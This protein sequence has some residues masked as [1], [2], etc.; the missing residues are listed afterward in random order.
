MST[1]LWQDPAFPHFYH[2]PAVVKPLEEAFRIEVAALDKRLARL[3]K[4]GPGFEDVLTEEIVA[5]SEIEGVILDRDSVHSS[6]VSNLPPVEEK[7]QGAVAL[8]RMALAHYDEPL[9]HGL[10]H[11]MHREILRGSRFPE[12]SIGSYVGDMKIVSGNRLDQE[13]KV[14]H[15]G[16]SKD[17]VHDKMTEFI[18]WYNQC[19]GD[20]PLVN[21]VQGHVHFET[22]HPFCDGNGR[23]GRNLVLMGLCRDL[24]RNTPLA[25]SRSFNAD[26]KNY[27]RQFEAGLDLTDTIQRVSP[28]FQSAVIETGRI[29]E[30][31]AYRARV[32][33]Q[34][35]DLNERQIKVLNR[36]I[37]Y[38]LR[39]GFKGGLNNAKYQKMTGIGDR[40][41]LRDLGELHARG[42]VVK[43]GQLKGTRYHLNIPHLVKSLQAPS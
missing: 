28:L 10:L 11:T 35:E 18:E 14:I 36:L 30:L 40:T 37:D 24:G 12:E 23:I 39:G 13:P 25:L 19:P 33:D 31:T 4:G 32:S 26:L 9:N 5:N 41:A 3:G 29:L 17:L 6:F 38:E 21:A 2:N 27:Y 8:T 15:E 7:E 43:V 42:L 16:V 1:Y 34:I 20:T 22:I